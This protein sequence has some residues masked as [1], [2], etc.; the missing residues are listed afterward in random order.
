LLS[1]GQAM[2]VAIARVLLKKP[3]ILLLDEATAAL[4]EK[5]QARIVD[6]IE[7]D[8]KDKTVIM[9][10]HRL[11]TITNF[12][13]I[14]VFDRGH[15]IQQGKYQEL[16]ETPGL[17]QDLV[18]QER[19]EPVLSVAPQNVSNA[20]LESSSEIQRA[21]SLSPIFADLPNE[22]IA[23]LEHMSKTVESKRDTVLF[24][25]GDEGNEFFI[26]LSGEIDFFVTS[27]DGRNTKI[28]NTYGPG[29]SFGELSLFADVKRTVGAKAKTDLKLCII[30]RDDLL[31]LIEIKP[32][33]SFTF[34]KVISKQ[35]AQL[36]EGKSFNVS[37]NN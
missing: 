25:R 5:S 32:E 34:L 10:S 18:R 12:S 20:Q 33:L 13:R 28:V 7:D 21:A 4:D 16:V 3:N 30:S 8:F 1:G 11:S 17:F 22:D 35:L 15:I 27:D 14:L 6:L 36:S 29:N 23:L 26:I 31:K 2:K 19:G 37:K 24:N 9:I